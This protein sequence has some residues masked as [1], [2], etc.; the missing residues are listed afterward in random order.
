MSLQNIND[1]FDEYDIVR[2]DEDDIVLSFD[3]GDADLNDFIMK[4]ASLYRKSLLSVSYALLKKCNPD[5]IVGFFSM[6][7]DKVALGDFA[8]KTEFNR[9]RKKQGFPQSKRLKSYP[10]VKI[11]RLAVSNGYKGLKI[12][13]FLLDFVKTYFVVDNKSGCRFL[14]VDAYIQAIPFYEKNGFQKL[15]LVNEGDP[16]TRLLFYDLNAIAS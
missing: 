10:A 15:G 4:E 7:N 8:D 16:H 9:F 6:A 13:S 5:E 12:G 11:C 14:T 2:L 1:F 3:C